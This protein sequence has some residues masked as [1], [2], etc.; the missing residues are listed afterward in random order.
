MKKENRTI[1]RVYCAQ[2]NLK[3]VFSDFNSTSVRIF[4]RIYNFLFFTFFFG[5]KLSKILKFLRLN[6][7]FAQRLKSMKTNSSLINSKNV[8]TWRCGQKTWKKVIFSVVTEIWTHGYTLELRRSTFWKQFSDAKDH[9][10][11]KSIT[12]IAVGVDNK[13]HIVNFP[14][15]STQKIGIFYTE[16]SLKNFLMFFRI[17]FK[18]QTKA[19]D[20]MHL[21]RF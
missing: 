11:E 17:L 6:W 3:F 9:K 1:G 8:L 14:K 16:K 18:W 4:R 13:G 12:R 15:F 2:V 10:D 19:G 7:K 21:V 5:R 20:P